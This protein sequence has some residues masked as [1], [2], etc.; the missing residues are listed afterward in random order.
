MGGP[1]G[2][3]GSGGGGGRRGSQP[4]E[5]VDGVVP[6]GRTDGQVGEC[7]EGAAP[8]KHSPQGLSGAQAEERRLD[9]T[10]GCNICL[11]TQT[12]WRW[13]RRWHTELAKDRPNAAGRKCEEE[14]DE[15]GRGVS[16]LLKPLSRAGG[17]GWPH[18][19]GLGVV[20][21]GVPCVSRDHGNTRKWGE[22]A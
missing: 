20:N 7:T 15:A 1:R 8:H 18:P 2:S 11:R 3:G 19:Q 4:C 14:A 6:R 21:S 5:E 12:K 22:A 16:S 10:D 13:S 9:S 17:F